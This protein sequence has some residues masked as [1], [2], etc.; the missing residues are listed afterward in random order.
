MFLQPCVLLYV[1]VL[2]CVCVLLFIVTFFITK[3]MIP[4]AVHRCITNL[5]LPALSFLIGLKT[6]LSLVVSCLPPRPQLKSLSVTVAAK[7]LI[8]QVWELPL[9][10]F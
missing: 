4:L 10:Y 5:I 3:M 7:L 9:V 6:L 8:V 2:D 1:S